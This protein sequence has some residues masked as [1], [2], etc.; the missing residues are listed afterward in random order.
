MQEKLA[1]LLQICSRKQSYTP[2][3]RNWGMGWEGEEGKDR[4][5]E[6]KG[7]S[8]EGGSITNSESL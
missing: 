5:R 6:G 7:G 2:V 3:R 4:G 8:E 1:V